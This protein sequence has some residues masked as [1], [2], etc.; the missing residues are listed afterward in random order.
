M[1]RVVVVNPLFA[2]VGVDEGNI[3]VKKVDENV[4][5]REDG[6]DGKDVLDAVAID[7]DDVET[8][9]GGGNASISNLS[10]FVK[11]IEPLEVI[12]STW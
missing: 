9:V 12:I 7:V 11:T 1:T 4:T 6:K 2:I 10:D 3:L 5:V 8:F